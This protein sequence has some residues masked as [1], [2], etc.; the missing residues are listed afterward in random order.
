MNGF[1]EHGY[2]TPDQSLDDAKRYAIFHGGT[3]V[4]TAAG[5]IP[6]ADWM[7]GY[8]P[9]ENTEVFFRLPDT[10]KDDGRIGEIVLNYS[11]LTTASV[12]PIFRQ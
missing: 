9:Q 11:L 6:L 4:L 7:T 1:T 10:R 12:F 2:P 5:F 3:H 8:E